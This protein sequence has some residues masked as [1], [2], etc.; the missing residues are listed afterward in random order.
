MGEGSSGKSSRNPRR[1]GSCGAEGVE[2]L[3]F[4][5]HETP[6]TIPTLFHTVRVGR[7]QERQS[8]EPP[9]TTWSLSTPKLLG[10]CL[11]TLS[12]PRRTLSTSQKTEDY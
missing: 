9:P 8:L 5:E 4:W 11:A 6:G 10:R 3:L 12:F 1:P 2:V 7:N